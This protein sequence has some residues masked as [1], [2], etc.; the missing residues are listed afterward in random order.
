MIHEGH[1]NFLLSFATI[2][3]YWK[4]D[5]ALSECLGPPSTIDTLGSG[6]GLDPVLS[7]GSDAAA[8]AAEIGGTLRYGHWVISGGPALA[9]IV[10]AWLHH[11]C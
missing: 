5:W 10:G 4:N 11:R 3:K 1:R 2:A 6:G 8:A 7:E 9:Q